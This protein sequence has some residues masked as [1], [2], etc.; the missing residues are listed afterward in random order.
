MAQLVKDLTLSLLWLW[1]QWRCGFCFVVVFAVAVL[2]FFCFFLFLGA[3]CIAHESPQAR[4]QI[5]VITASMC[6]SDSNARPKPH[7]SPPPQLTATPISLT[8]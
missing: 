6:H 5:G 3:T 4:G 8:H 2:G 1:L 7:L